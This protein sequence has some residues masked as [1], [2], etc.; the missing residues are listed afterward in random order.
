MTRK[1]L[2]AGITFGLLLCVPQ[3]TAQQ[4]EPSRDPRVSNRVEPYGPV[5]QRESTSAARNQEESLPARQQTE[6]PPPLT[7]VEAVTLQRMGQTRSYFVPHLHLSQ[8]VDTNR[9]GVT[10]G[11]A[12]LF[13][14]SLFNAGI[15]VDRLWR[16]YQLTA[17]Y[18]GGGLIP[19]RRTE[20]G[21]RN[22]FFHQAGFT[23][24]ITLRNWQFLLSDYFSL[25]P[26]SA[27][28]LP[29]GGLLNPGDIGIGHGLGEGGPILNT[30]LLPSQDFF[31]G[32]SRRISNAAVGQVL[33][34]LTRRSS[35]TAS[36]AF[37]VLHF[38]DGDL[39]DGRSANFSAG[40]NYLISPQDTLAVGYTHGRFW[41]IGSDL[42]VTSHN[43]HL[44]Y[45]HQ[46]SDRMALVISGG[47]D[48]LIQSAPG[49]LRNERLSWSVRGVLNYLFQ[50]STLYLSY[51]HFLN[52]GSGVFTGARTHHVELGWNRQLT[53]HWGWNTRL[54]YSRNAELAVRGTDGR[55][56]HS[57]LGGMSFGRPLGRYTDIFFSYDVQR[58]QSSF[59][60]CVGTECGRVMLRHMFGIGFRFGYRPIEIE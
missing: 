19:N 54:A 15:T 45:G 56:F 43:L 23:Q 3:A 1:L 13:S 22:R 30:S 47:P 4:K 39:L 52:G 29:A 49:G 35:I 44:G 2:V 20:A 28:G 51:Y 36:G 53:R 21:D 33:R 24:R 60:I 25:L 42:V 58:Q 17:H 11:D 8:T 16:N 31:S 40:Y 41:F 38:L 50:R 26:E 34:Q 48:L 55:R 57:V 5:E 59:P 46:I 14:Y 27:F 10:V 37:G 6:T 7:G 12:D 18:S 9:R 32:D